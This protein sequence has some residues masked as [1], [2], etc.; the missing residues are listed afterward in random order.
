VVDG[1]GMGREVGEGA[2]TGTKTANIWGNSFHF[3][4]YK[5]T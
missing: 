1:E 5:A 2:G 3:G 4:I